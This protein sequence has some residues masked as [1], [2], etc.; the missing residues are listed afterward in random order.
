MLICY[1]LGMSNLIVLVIIVFLLFIIAILVSIFFKPKEELLPYLK[2]QYL[3]TLKERELF[4]ILNEC[5]PSTYY[6][7][8]QIHVASILEVKKGETRWQMWFNKIISKSID[9]VIFDK[10][11][12]SPILAIELDDHTHTY[13]RRM[14]R[15]GFV[16]Q[17]IKS[18]NIRMLRFKNEDL[19][20]PLNIKSKILDQLNLTIKT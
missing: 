8:P 3:M 19:S 5:V 10:V 16:N 6:V 4:S 7:F 17:A 1:T 2:K 11:N 20:D 18:G 15:D 12:I 13:M 14:E 9:F